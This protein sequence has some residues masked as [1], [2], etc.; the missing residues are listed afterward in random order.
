MAKAPV[1]T[2]ENLQNEPSAVGNIN[3][4]FTVLSDAIERSLSRGNEEGSPANQM[5]DVLDMNNNMII[6]LPPPTTPTE[7]ARHGDIQQYVDQAEDA[8]NAAEGF[9]DETEGF[10]DE[11]LVYRDETEGFWESFQARYLGVQATDPELD[12]NGDPLTEGAIYFNSTN[13]TWRV[14]NVR[15]VYVDDEPVYVGDDLVEV[16]M[17]E[18]LPRGTLN[19][20]G[21]VNSGS[22]DHGDFLQWNNGT[23]TWEPGAFAAS[24]VSYDNVTSG[25]AASNV[26]AAID[27]VV[28][29][30]ILK[31]FDLSFFIAGTVGSAEMI[32]K[33]VA[34]QPFYLPANLT[35]SVGDA[36]DAAAATHA[37]DI[38]KN[39]I[40]VGTVNWAE[41]ATTPTFTLA[42][43]VDF[44]TG[45]ILTLIG[46][47]GGDASLADIALT[48]RA[49]RP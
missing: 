14:Y 10:R 39:G 37:W 18:E 45:D 17:W 40:T 26:Q 8:A 29:G 36:E 30:I 3:E 7:P 9:R 19:S 44:L 46:A 24:G 38:E 21:D 2:V 34:A 20:L 41:S 6:N 22:L 48:I 49:W 15:T 23:Q 33:L 4:N 12:L 31:R 13:R 28:D 27:E 42:T 16:H 32:W 43:Q 25:L 5:D 11:T 35:G 1:V 47:G